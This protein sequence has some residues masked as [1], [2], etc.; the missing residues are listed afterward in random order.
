MAEQTIDVR[1]VAGSLGADVFGADLSRELS[2][3]AYDEIHQAFLDHQV[4]FIRDQKL[5]PPQ[6]AAFARRFGPLNEYPFVKGLEEAPE[7]IEIVKEPD[8]TVNF[9]GVW[10]SD[11]TYLDNPPMGTALY[12][13]EVPAAGGDTMYANMY[14]AYDALSVG[15]KNMLAPMIGVSSAALRRTGGRAKGMSAQSTMTAL[16]MDKAETVVAEHPVIR[17]HSETGRKA[18]YVN[19][20]HTVRFKDDRRRKQTVD[21]VS[22]QSRGP[23]RIYVPF[24]M[25][26]WDACCLGQSLCPA[27]RDQ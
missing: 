10:H 20:A 15:M 26:S 12:A 13:L 5:T 23:S 16:N 2:N 11:T 4:L 8:E 27:F 9:G 14:D 22:V 18:L 6:L 3:Q 1:R 25:G 19:S 24:S 21:R 7:I 17:T